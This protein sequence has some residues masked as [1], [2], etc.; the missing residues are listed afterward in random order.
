M[1]ERQVKQCSLC[2]KMLNLGC[3]HLAGGRLRS[4][5]KQCRSI[6][7]SNKAAAKA[8]VEPSPART[9]WENLG[10]EYRNHEVYDPHKY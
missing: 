8:I 6:T 5:C 9:K 3:F 2:H 7:E 10:L 1:T 4:E